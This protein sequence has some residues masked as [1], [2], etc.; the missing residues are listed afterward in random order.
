ML[1]A[2]E[3]GTLGWSDL[4]Q[5]RF[6]SEQGR[7]LI[8][9]NGRDFIAETLAAFEAQRPHAGVLIVPRS[10]PNDHFTAVAQALCAYAAR[11]PDG[12]QPYTIDFLS[13]EVGA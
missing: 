13:P 8:T 3:A 11:F 5:L 2:V 7:C 10:V 6:A 4:A 1:T 9:R 12:M